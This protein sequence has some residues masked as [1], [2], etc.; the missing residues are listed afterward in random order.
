MRGSWSSKISRPSQPAALLPLFEPTRQGVLDQVAKQRMGIGIVMLAEHSVLFSSATAW[1]L[2]PQPNHHS[3]NGC[4]GA[5]MTY[6][7]W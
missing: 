3:S 5:S 4:Q 1:A 7:L 2:V 6:S